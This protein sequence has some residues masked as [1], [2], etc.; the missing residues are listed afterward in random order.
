MNRHTLENE[1][2]KLNVDKEIQR[3]MISLWSN[4]TMSTFEIAEELARINPRMIKLMNDW[5]SGELKNNQLTS[6]GYAIALMNYCKTVNK[7][8]KLDHFI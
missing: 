1:L 6:V 4:S 8:I 3:K 7:K 2:T 5:K